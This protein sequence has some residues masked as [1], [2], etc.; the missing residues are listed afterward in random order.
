VE[1]KPDNR[2]PDQVAKTQPDNMTEPKHYGMHRHF[3]EAS[4]VLI[5]GGGFRKG[6]VYGK[7]AE[8]RPCKIVENPVSVED[9]HAT[10]YRAMGIPA[11]LAYTVEGRPFHVTK[12]GVGKPILDLFA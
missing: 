9:L 7:T 11:D 4:S 6:F 10:L 12:D 2:V 1:G 5:F 3:T 8:E